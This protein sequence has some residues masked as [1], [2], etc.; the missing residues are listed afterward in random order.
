M[1]GCVCI[2][3]EVY[4]EVKPVLDKMG[5]VLFDRDDYR[6]PRKEMSNKPTPPF[7]VRPVRHLKEV[8]GFVCKCVSLFCTEQESGRRVLVEVYLVGDYP[9][10]ASLDEC[11]IVRF[12]AFLHCNSELLWDE[13]S[14][15]CGELI[16][17]QKRVVFEDERAAMKSE[18]TN[19][20][21]AS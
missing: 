7:R 19:L 17:D 8:E 18:E 12:A 16:P 9:G 11:S 10:F 21:A 3:E 4:L 15:T 20:C 14:A 2:G 13:A 6:L 1:E 5:I